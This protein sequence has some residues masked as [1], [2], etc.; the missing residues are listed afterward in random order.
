MKK[1]FTTIVFALAVA[2]AGLAQ[3]VIEDFENSGNWYWSPWTVASGSVGGTKSSS[4][5]HSGSN[6]LNSGGNGEWMLNTSV[7]VGS[8]GHILSWWIR[9]TGSGRAYFGFGATSGG[10]YNLCAAPNTS[11]FIVQNST[12]WNFTD[13]T[14]VSQTW[15]LNQWYRVEVKFNSTTDIVGNLYGSDGVTLINTISY[16]ISGLNPGGVAFRA[17]GPVDIDDIRGGSPTAGGGPILPPIANFYPGQP[18]NHAPNVD[19]VWINSPYTLVN[20]SS[21]ATRVYWDIDSPASM[22][23]NTGYFRQNVKWTT[24]Q[25]LDTTKWSNNFTYTFTSPGY[26]KIRLLAINDFKS[27]S[28]RDSVTKYIY[29]DTPSQAPKVNFITFKR[30]VGFGDYTKFVDLSTYGP[31]QWNWTFSPYCNKCGNTPFFPNFFSPANSATPYFFGGD[32]GVYTVCLQA[33]NAR[34]TDTACKTDYVTVTN[35]YYMCSGSGSLQAT[36]NEGYVFGPSGPNFSYTRSQIGSCPGFLLAPC[37]DSV[38]LFV[39]RIKMLPTDSVVFYNGVN[40][41]A[42]RIKAVGAGSTGQGPLADS[43]RSIKGGRNIFM[44]FKLGTGA[45]PSPYD[46]AGFSIHWWIKPATYPKP[47][48]KFTFPDTLYSNSPVVYQNQS[49]GTLVKYSW[50]TDGN[51]SYDSTVANP[52]R[53]FVITTPTLKKICLVAFNCVG[54]DTACKNVVFLPITTRPVARFTVDKITGFNTDTFYFKDKSLNGPATWK[55]TFT[56]G[57]FQYL[58]GTSS[59]D[60]EPNVRFVQQ[61]QYNVKLVACNAYG[62]DS[63]IKDFYINIGAYGSFNPVISAGDATNGIGI[64]RVQLAGIDTS[65]NAYSP[66]YQVITGNQVGTLYRGVNYPLVVTRPNANQAMDRKVWIDY[67]LNGLFEDNGELVLNETAGTTLSKTVN[68]RIPDDQRIGTT[69]MRVAVGLPD[70]SPPLSSLTAYIGSARDYIISFPQDTV[71]PVVVLKGSNVMSAEIHK[72][73]VDPGVEAVDNLEGDISGKYVLVGNVDTS[74]VGPNFLSYVVSDLYG[75]V[76]D[77]VKRLVFVELNRTGPTLELKGASILRNEVKHAF[78]DPGWTAKDNTGADISS[79]VVVTGTVDSSRLGSYPLIYRITDAFGISAQATRLVIVTDTTKPVIVSAHGNPFIHQVGAYFDPMTAVRVVDNYNT[80]LFPT[81]SGVVDVNNVGRY[82]IVYD[83][84]DLSGNI[85]DE[86]ILTVDVK[87]TIPPTIQLNGDN[88]L[89]IEVFSTFSDPFVIVNDNYWPRNTITV[90][91]TGT[92]NTSVVGSYAKVYTAKDPSG[93]TASVTRT[94]NVVKTSLPV[95]H[96]LGANPV[97]LK[98]FQPYVEQGASIEDVYFSNDDLQKYLIIDKSR[99]RTDMP[100]LYSVSYDVSDMFGNKAKTVSR[101]INVSDEVSGILDHGFAEGFNLYPV[102]TTGT[103][104]VE[105]L[106]G[107]R[108]KA[109]KVFNVLG[110]EVMTVTATQPGA[111]K[112]DLGSARPGVYIL[113]VDAGDE[114]FTRKINVV[115]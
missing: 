98:R 15:N 49:T 43:V 2:T 46:S 38:Y 40:A 92:V 73:F 67:N 83:A 19:T 24:Q 22:P 72:P 3:P 8:P 63:I 11:T 10:C 5:A 42:P 86:F 28:L 81:Y 36:D 25:Y 12:G 4:S 80:N 99:V 30:T 102:P 13:M 21:S 66:V 90:T 115:R 41:S 113:K 54:S 107:R 84:R 27:D 55:W 87:D 104:Y 34:G 58:N 100:G 110:E 35:S 97:N 108:V 57:G 50:D 85:A 44:A 39:E 7:T 101:T 91:T 48:A 1:V 96:L 9:F 23:L 29:V 105:P 111:V 59:T 62:C 103:L 112:V 68:I 32:P 61:R 51:G 74:Q 78:I 70:A 95:I 64:S 79:Q 88:P 82:Y 33:W 93:N 17:F 52:S 53:S 75:N 71:K 47:T 60:K 16:T 18:Q 6:G 14:S 77:T 56:G 37:A 20:T 89:T 76:S 31:N 94:I 69:R 65:T 106:G 45:V 114:T 26:W 109:V